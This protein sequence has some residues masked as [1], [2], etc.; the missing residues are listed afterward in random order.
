MK[1][2]NFSSS[3]G[4]VKRIEEQIQILQ[5]IIIEFILLYDLSSYDG[6]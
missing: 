4:V 5:K 6:S 3:K 2:H 1:I